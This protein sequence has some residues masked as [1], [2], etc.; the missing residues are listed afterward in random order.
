M[1]AKAFLR[2]A[3]ATRVLKPQLLRKI[4][5]SGVAARKNLTL[6]LEFVEEKRFTYFQNDLPS[7]GDIIAEGRWGG[8]RSLYRA[9]VEVKL[10]VSPDSIK[11]LIASSDQETLIVF[12]LLMNG[13]RRTELAKFRYQ[14]VGDEIHSA[15]GTVPV[16]KS[17]RYLLRHSKQALTIFPL[18]SK[19]AADVALQ[20]INMTMRYEKKISTGLRI[21]QRAFINLALKLGDSPERIRGAHRMSFYRLKSLK[22]I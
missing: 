12:A 3:D 1:R 9:G 22:L 20:R 10:R 5:T 17:C 15:A 18:K 8:G 11:K 4:Q 19:K 2:A 14:L 21:W 13:A 7:M 16:L 6:F